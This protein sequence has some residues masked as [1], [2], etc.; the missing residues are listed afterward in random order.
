MKLFFDNKAS[1]II[2]TKVAALADNDFLGLI[3]HDEELLKEVLTLFSGKRIYLYPFTEFEFL[4]DIFVSQIRVL[5][6][7]FIAKSIFG[8]IKQENH[9]RVFPKLYENALLLSRIFA[10]QG[11]AGISSFVDLLLAGLLMYLKDKVILITG[12]KRHYPS[13]VFDTLSVL[14]IE[15]NDGSMRAFCIIAFSQEKFNSCLEKLTRL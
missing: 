5:A 8:H 12:N 3:Y 9:L 1:E 7:Q 4:R 14:N 2:Q 15:Q 11:Y 10:H 6:E 13:C